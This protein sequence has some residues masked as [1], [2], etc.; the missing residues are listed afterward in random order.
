MNP[1]K[2]RAT[3]IAVGATALL[4]ASSMAPIATASP[5][6][7]HPS[8]VL[9]WYDTTAETIAMGGSSAQITNS[10]TWAISWIAAARAV[11]KVPHGV[12]RSDYQ[13][14][15]LAS[16][17]H[18]SLVTLAPMRAAALDT[19]LQKT[20]DGVEDS[21]AER[22]GK[23]AGEH[24]ARKVLTS[25]EGDGLD[26]ASVNATFPVP[27]PRPGAW[28]PTAP[29]FSPAI[30]Y[31]S[32]VARPFLLKEADQFRLPPPPAL[33]SN[34]YQRDLE[35]V[36]QYGK[37][38]STVRS[39]EQTDIANFWYDSSLSLLTKPIRI[40]LVVSSSQSVKHQAELVATVNAALVDT[41]IATSDS[42]YAYQLWRPITAI[43]TADH[44]DPSWTPL[45]NTPAH[46]DYPSGHNTYAGAVESLLTAFVGPRSL[47]FTLTSSTAPGVTRT[48]TS[49]RQIT[50]DNTEARVLQ[51]IHTRFA[52]EGGVKLGTDVARYALSKS[53]HLF[54]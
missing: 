20:L 46:P 6:R 42:K 28:Q 22:L 11:Q 9:D 48:Y 27:L 43:R 12:D 52:D 32:R 14:A 45:R 13:D 54:H 30:Q 17:V 49:W 40:A 10:R 33:D 53:A 35:E 21:R 19:A 5:E 34:R 25:R 38:N 4:A 23:A 37:L 51:G 41:Q 24:Q 2:T 3:L 7:V 44:P 1:L 50:R 39:K 31:G 18:R 15:A 36:R 8:T 47:P 16:A 26:T 29:T